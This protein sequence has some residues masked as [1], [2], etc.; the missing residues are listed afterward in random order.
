MNTTHTAM[1][2]FKDWY[3]N[4]TDMY[5][6]PP[7]PREVIDYIEKH[8]LLENEMIKNVSVSFAMAVDNV[9]TPNKETIDKYNFL[10][11]KFIKK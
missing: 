2:K 1:Y 8:S 9:K 3:M 5:K 7:S 11:D 10:Y 4:H 6:E